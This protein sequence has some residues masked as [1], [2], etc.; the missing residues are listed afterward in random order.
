MFKRAWRSIR[1]FFYKKKPVIVEHLPDEEV[2]IPSR[3]DS[4]FNVIIPEAIY[5]PDRDI[6]PGKYNWSPTDKN[7]L[8]IGHVTAGWQ[9]QK[10]RD[11]FSFMK[12]HGYFTDFIDHT[13]NIFQQ[14]DGDETG[15]HVGKS[16]WVDHKG[17]KLS[18]LNKYSRGVEMACGG[19]L[20]IWKGSTKKSWSRKD[21]PG[22]WD[23]RTSFGKKI[24]VENRRYVTK[25]EGYNH[26][27]WY[28]VLTK[29][30]EEGYAIWCIDWGKRGINYKRMLEH[31]DVAPNRRTD[32]GGCLSMPHK[33]FI[34]TKV[35]PKL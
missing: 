31:A 29:E 18:Y 3:S 11:F 22:G 4:P 15:A 23:L 25:T 33:K 27:G 32:I 26:S 16:E 30:Q 34:E 10:A 35:L 21:I 24:H 19:K 20:K 12:R 9:K 8:L 28:E 17:R 13:G 2:D 7:S 5:M 6:L 14:G 1:R